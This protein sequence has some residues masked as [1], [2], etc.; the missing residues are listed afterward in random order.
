MLKEMSKV[1]ATASLL[2]ASVAA[3]AAPIG[4]DASF[5][6]GWSGDRSFNGTI[7]G[8]DSN[9]DGLITTDEVTAIYESY[10]GHTLGA[11]TAIGSIDI[12]TQTWNF[13]GLSWSGFPNYAYM[14]FDNRSW[15]CSA[16]NGC[17]VTFTSFQT[18]GVDLPE[19]AS[20]ALFG[21]AFAGLALSRRKA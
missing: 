18:T 6:F 20:M 3:Q 21:L 17:G 14:T 5:T 10:D 15:S 2:L 19:P 13:D 7:S 4:V 1:L 8:L 11:L 12:A 16:Y 9:A